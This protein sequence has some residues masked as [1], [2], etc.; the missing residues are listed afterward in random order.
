[1]KKIFDQLARSG[2]LCDDMEA[3]IFA[4]DPPSMEKIVAEVLDNVVLSE[5]VIRGDPQ[6]TLNEKRIARQCLA[7]GFLSAIA[8]TK[9]QE[10]RL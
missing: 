10:T 3:A 4:G 5:A 7:I 9:E 2:L 6:S 8:G 1:M